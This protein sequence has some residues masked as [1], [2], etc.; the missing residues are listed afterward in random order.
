MPVSIL[1]VVDF[2]LRLAETEPAPTILP[3]SIL[4]V[5]DFP[6]R[7]CQVIFLQMVKGSFNPCC[8]G[9]SFATI[10]GGGHGI[11]ER[12]FQSLL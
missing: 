3:V 8:S 12:L 9:F 10:T 11:D 1:V 2:P 5:V 4:V 7:H 6:L